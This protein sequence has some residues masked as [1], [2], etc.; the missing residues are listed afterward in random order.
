MGAIQSRLRFTTPQDPNTPATS[1]LVDDDGLAVSQPLITSGT[2]S[3]DLTSPKEQ[4]R[5]GD[6]FRFLDLPP[7]IDNMIYKEVLFV[8]KVH[9]PKATDCGKW[10]RHAWKYKSLYSLY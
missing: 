4:Q 9:F 6:H 2:P 5:N 7:E 1:V 10:D 8:S 3:P